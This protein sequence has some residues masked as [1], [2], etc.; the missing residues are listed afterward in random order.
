MRRAYLEA[1]NEQD[2][3][4]EPQLHAALKEPWV[5]VSAYKLECPATALTTTAMRPKVFD[6]SLVPDYQPGFSGRQASN[7]L[8][9]A[10][11]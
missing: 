1:F 4:M 8:T 7:S 2:A 3:R 6:D 10:A 5:I 11:S 9:S